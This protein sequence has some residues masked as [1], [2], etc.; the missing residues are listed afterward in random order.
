MSQ[1]LITT[2][3]IPALCRCG[4]LTLT[5][6]AE[7]IHATVD[8]IALSTPGRLAAILTGRIL[9]ALDVDGL[10]ERTSWRQR[11]PVAPTLAQHRCGQPIP[12]AWHA[13]PDAGR[14]RYVVPDTCPF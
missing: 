8:P 1:H 7:G 4:A 6:H 14:T 9:Y 13:P 11:Y 5:G 3:P 10:V 2:K 12:A